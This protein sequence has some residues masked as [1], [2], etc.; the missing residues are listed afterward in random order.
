MHLLA[1][2]R[3]A[4]A[5]HPWAY[6]LAVGAVAVAAALGVDHAMADVEAARRSWGQQQTVWVASSAIEPGQ[7][8]V[9][10]SQSVPL[11]VVP[12]GAVSVAPDGAI[13]RQRLGP[14][15]IITDVDLAAGGPAGL[16]PDGWIAFAVLAPVEHFAIG[17]SVRVFANDQSVAGGLVVDHGESDVMV[18]IPVEAAAAMAAGLLAG[19]VTIALAPG[20]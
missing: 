14:G 19:T 9:S 15:E 6:W 16:I 17:D 1:R 18:A 4:V 5:R 13:A 11:A 8:I 12:P 10:I 20:P 3:L 7:S 2:V